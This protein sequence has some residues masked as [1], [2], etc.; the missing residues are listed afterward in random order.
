MFVLCPH[1]QFLVALDPASGRPPA[2][3]P[4]CGEPVQP[5]APAAAAAATP[6]APD[7]APTPSPPAVMPGDVAVGEAVHVQAPAA[8]PAEAEA[9]AAAEADAQ[10]PAE[11]EAAAPPGEEAEAPAPAQDTASA[12]SPAEPPAAPVSVPATAAPEAASA[13]PARAG[14]TARML[15]RARAATPVPAAEPAP[16]EAAPSRAPRA[17][18]GRS[19]PVEVAPVAPV[20]APHADDGADAMPSL[21]AEELETTTDAAATPVAA[22]VLAETVLGPA[23]VEAELVVPGA[24]VVAPEPASPVLSDADAALA[25]PE[26]VSTELPAEDVAPLPRRQA[27]SFARVPVARRTPPRRRALK[28]LAIA[29]LAALLVLQGLLADR[30]RLAADARWRPLVSALCAPLRCTLPPWREPAAFTVL[31]RDVRPRPDRPGVLHATATFRNDARWPQ[32][33]PSL[34]LTLSDVDGRVVG[35][36]EFAPREYLGAAPHGEI[37]SGQGASVAIDIVEPT[38]RIVA[39]T[40]DFR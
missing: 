3:C 6:A 35:A 16:A 14:L 32:P 5:D 19:A 34:L 29:G 27:P 31:A 33:W 11:A 9:P 4:R 39:F 24:E 7:A 15:R 38:P 8:A 12:A 26:P 18:R 37:A 40:F 20:P 21:P 22:D 23:M 28:A 10:A 13:P 36:R 1:C 30:A 17:R 2:R 25:A